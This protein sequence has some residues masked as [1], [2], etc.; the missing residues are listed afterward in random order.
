MIVK[1]IFFNWDTFYGK[2]IKIGTGSKW[3]HVGI[4]GEDNDE[5]F[6]IYEAV[7]KGLVKTKY[8]NAQIVELM[9]KGIVSVKEVYI[10]DNIVNERVL[11]AYCEKYIGRPYDWL[12]IFNIGFYF[13]F[14]KYA[15]NFKGAR[16][17]ICSEF[18]SRVLYDLSLGGI[19][20]EEEYDKP[21]DYISP[22]D[23][24]NSKI[25]EKPTF[26]KVLK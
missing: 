5:G 16:T 22:A 11:K 21:Y 4:V 10:E 13:I 19:N 8:S 7:N 26:K 17:L 15:L 25:F 23:I 18:V 14:R 6:I 9:L 2:L 3:T 12:S 20:F 1:V 24:Y